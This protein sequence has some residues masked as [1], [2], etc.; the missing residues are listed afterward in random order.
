VRL[1]GDNPFTDVDELDRLIALHLHG[2]FDY[3]HS[4]GDLPAG[5]GAEIFTF[6]ALE[7]VFRDGL[8]P[9]HREHVNE[10]VLENRSRF[11]VGRLEVD[12]RK[13]LPHVRLT[14][15]TEDDLRRA[16]FVLERCGAS[17]PST[18][19]ASRLWSQSA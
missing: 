11:S 14:I 1:T 10:Y 8:A 4:I 6:A 17:W 3:S 7:R 16:R 19:E 9:H 12:A 18:A 2:G 5:A 13:R 15:D